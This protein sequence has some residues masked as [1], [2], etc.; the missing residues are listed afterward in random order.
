MVLH[1]M[2][3]RTPRKDHGLE[4]DTA[5]AN[6]LPMVKKRAMATIW[7]KMLCVVLTQGNLIMPAVSAA[8]KIEKAEVKGKMTLFCAP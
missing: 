5:A 2:S 3:W 4:T 6:K 1:Q 8:H 7:A